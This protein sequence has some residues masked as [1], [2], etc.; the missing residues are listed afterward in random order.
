MSVSEIGFEGQVVIITGGGQGLGASHAC[1]FA[2][3][4]ARV[5]INDIPR[6]GDELSKAELLVQEIRDGGGEA[7]FAPAYIGS[8]EA[9]KSIVDVALNAFGRV[10]I[11]VNNAGITLD[12]MFHKMPQDSISKV[13]AI[14]LVGAAHLTRIVW[15][16]MKEQGFGRIVNTTSAASFGNAG[17]G[18]YASAKAGLIGL[19]N[20]L[21]QE[22]ELH[23]IRV[24][25][26]A[27]IARTPMTDELFQKMGIDLP[28]DPGDVTPVVISL[29]DPSEACVNGRIIGCASGQLME[30]K[31]AVVWRQNV[32]P[33]GELTPEAVRD[34]LANPPQG[35]EP[36][37]PTNMNDE[38]G[39]FITELMAVTV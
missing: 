21:A 27:P 15:E 17:Q 14:H 8:I 26:I 36:F 4:G 13:L 23:G 12:K 9:A 35:Q 28:L 5:V 37:Y 32:A 1:E 25:A 31:L 19:T 11:L 6:D 38:I 33:A 20:S 7:V 3:L 18:N 24:N 10:D 16:M 39:R 30:I 22:A 2:R 29:C 34:V